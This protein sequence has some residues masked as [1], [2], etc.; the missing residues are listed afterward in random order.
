MKKYSYIAGGLLVLLFALYLI[1]RA[2][3]SSKVDA[4]IDK[5]NLD[6]SSLSVGARDLSFN[7]FTVGLELDSVQL[8]QTVSG[9]RVAGTINRIDLT[10]LSVVKAISGDISINDLLVDGAQLEF[11]PA[12]TD[13]TSASGKKKNISIDD[14][15]L[16]NGHLL[17]F[18]KDSVLKTKV[19]GLASNGPLN[20]PLAPAT[21]PEI[22]VTAK[23]I[24]FPA[25]DDTDQVINDLRLDVA[26]GNLKI[27]T[28]LISPKQRARTFLTSIKY[29]RPW[30]A[31]RVA[32]IQIIG[33]P[34]DSLMAGGRTVVNEI[35]IGDLNFEIYENP[36]LERDPAEPRKLFP[37][38]K[39]RKI[40]GQF[41]LQSL[42]IERANIAYGVH[43]EGS[44]KPDIT[45]NGSIK[46]GNFSTWK[47]DEPAFAQVDCTFEE[48]S[49]L[50][51]RFNF[52][53]SGEGREFS[54]TG[55]LKDYDLT[56]INPLMV[57]A[58]NTDVEK[59]NINHLTHDF[60]V[61][62]GI[63]RGELVLKYD[64]LEVKMVGK[65]AWLIN[66]FEDIVIRDSN[67]RNDGDL[68]IGEVYAEHDPTKSFFNLYWKSLVSGMAS[69]VAG[70]VFLPKEN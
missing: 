20:L 43:K 1:G 7:F 65:N 14:L 17:I 46:A 9:R 31:L 44:E 53:Q 18:G 19:I 13:S 3:V 42:V 23:S 45:F 52:D 58:A 64:H 54:A 29:K 28:F 5:A 27:G 4:L 32:G 25:S 66:I 47:Q 8:N 60:S 68:V 59:G 2:F 49:P 21:A 61:R 51:V 69:S 37:V 50:T 63:A 10:G 36:E 24:I 62:D 35:N 22:A 6:G 11:Y 41:W 48:S 16:T 56:N 26:G 34:F 12:A 15:R 38:E 55:D 70:K 40:G 57:V 39:F 67:P 30:Q 33:F